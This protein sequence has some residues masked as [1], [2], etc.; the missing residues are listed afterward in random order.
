[1]PRP[2]LA[3]L[4]ATLLCAALPSQIQH[5]SARLTGDQEVP[6]VATA[7][8]GWALVTVNTATNQIDVFAH[9]LGL[10]AVAAHLH[11]GAPGANG[12]VV[13]PMAGGPQT[14][15]GTIVSPAVVAAIQ[16]GNTYVN[17][18]SA[19]NPGGQIR[20]QVLP[21]VSTRLLARLRGSEEVPP[22]GSTATGVMTAFLHEP[23]NVIVYELALGGIVPS[24]AH[25]HQGA[26]GV[27]GPV[28]VPLNGG[29]TR[30]CGVS[31]RLTSAQIASLRAGGMYV[32]VHS[33]AF[34]G[35]EIRGQL[36]VEVADFTARLDGASEVPPNPSAGVGRA[37]A[38][39][40]AD[41]TLTYRVEVSGLG[42]P[43]TAAHFHVGPIGVNGPVV[44]PLVGGPLVWAGTSAP[45]TS[46]QVAD[47]LAGRWYVNV[48]TTAFPGGEIRGQ[49]SAPALPKVF[50]FGCPAVPG[51]PPEI[52]ALG[53]AC[54]GTN[55]TIALHGAPA[56]QPA[57]LLFGF[58]RDFIPGFGRLPL[59][60]ALIGATDCFLLHD[61]PGAS[62]TT[63]TDA[64][65]CA[66]A[67]IGIPA[68]PSGG[69]VM[70][71]WFV[72]APGANPLGVG[73]SNGLEFTVH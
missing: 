62:L 15:T 53:I 70:A 22:N 61:N 51:T 59:S 2:T 68:M 6:P 19:A 40:N 23:G 72:I 4:F 52:G 36:L 11:Q 18:H 55:F 46:A 69:S 63:I 7:A 58:S 21:E 28:I 67:T 41:R 37:C 48:H 29:G 33:A 30:Y 45:L 17:L 27:N 60:L 47:L 13:V 49:V 10:V 31:Q 35:G 3:F 57:V 25:I 39:L 56:A 9:G 43:A 24:A 32:N 66:K 26:V 16:A 71:Q 20:G 42:A 14:W 50:G 8:H 38:I 73:S 5:F 54:V 64:L 1:M 44:V 12:P 65:G 34:P